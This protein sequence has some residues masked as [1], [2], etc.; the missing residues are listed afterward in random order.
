MPKKKK[1]KL[2]GLKVE[3]FVTMTNG[4]AKK[5]QG[6]RTETDTCQTICTDCTTDVSCDTCESCDTEICETCYTCPTCAYSCQPNCT[7][8]TSPCK[9]GPY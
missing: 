3:S 1:I 2:E 6:G 9:C 5:A 8:Y 4:Q 7:W